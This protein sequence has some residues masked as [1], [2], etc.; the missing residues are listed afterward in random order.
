M[1][2]MLATLALAFFALS[3]V[4]AD[5]VPV[6]VV[7]VTTFDND[8][9]NPKGTG[10]AD[11]EASRWIERMHLKRV[12]PLPGAFRPLH[13]NRDGVVEIETGMATARAASSTMASP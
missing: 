1:A 3:R 8:Y 6:K 11:G 9:N 7:I 12:V 5:P 4:V 2:R 10:E 13:M